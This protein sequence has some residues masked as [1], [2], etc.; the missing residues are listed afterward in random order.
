VQVLCPQPP[1]PQPQPHPQPPPTCRRRGQLRCALARGAQAGAQQGL[2]LAPEGVLGAQRVG[3]PPLG[4]AARLLARADLLRGGGGAARGGVLRL[5]GRLLRGL[6]LGARGAGVVLEAVGAAVHRRQVERVLLG[7]RLGLLQAVVRRRQ[8][9]LQRLDLGGVRGLEAVQLAAGLAR[10]R[11]LRL[12]RGLRRRELLRRARGAGWRRAGA[13]VRPQELFGG[14]HGH[15]A[16]TAYPMAAVAKRGSGDA[17]A[18]ARGTPG[19]ARRP[20]LLGGVAVGQ[21][22]VPLGLQP[23][24]LGERLGRGLPV[25][26]GRRVALAAQRLVGRSKLALRRLRGR[27]HRRE[28]VAALARRLHLARQARHLVLRLLEGPLQLQHAALG[29]AVG[30]GGRG[31]R[32]L[33]GVGGGMGKQACEAG[34]PVG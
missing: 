14:Q 15:A 6:E 33:G 20:H 30:A 3:Q 13:S 12:E 25:G 7:H 32:R 8:L 26:R 22:L 24:D 5:A 21:Q 1:P 4:V 9:R 27:Q 18:A 34:L 2:Q 29:A 31:A 19:P 16:P 28:V 17:A 10:Q 11:A 23:A